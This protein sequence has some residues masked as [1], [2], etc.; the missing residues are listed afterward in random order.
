MIADGVIQRLQV[1]GQL[2]HASGRGHHQKRLGGKGLDVGQLR[3]RVVP[4]LK[5]GGLQ[6]LLGVAGHF[7][8]GAVDRP[9][10]NRDFHQCS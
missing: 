4:G 8:G 2:T 1:V 10:K 5:T 3:P 9:G 7:F 6:Q